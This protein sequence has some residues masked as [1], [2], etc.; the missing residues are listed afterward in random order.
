MK[1]GMLT[2]VAIV[3]RST[4]IPFIYAVSLT[5]DNK[6][7]ILD[8]TWPH[9]AR[10]KL[11]GT[12]LGIDT[13]TLDAIDANNRRSEGCLNELITGWLRNIN[14]RPTRA[15]ITAVLNSEHILSAAGIYTANECITILYVVQDVAMYNYIIAGLVHNLL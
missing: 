9:R 3:A 2:E 1:I 5:P 14:P 10:W 11:I 7:E 13:G 15:A 4:C 8:V 6:R 12:E